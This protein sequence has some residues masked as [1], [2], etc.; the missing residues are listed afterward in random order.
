MGFSYT[1]RDKGWAGILKG[2]KAATGASVR[3]GILDDRAH[4][5]SKNGESIAE[6]VAVN[7]FGTGTIPSR[8]AWRNAFDGGKKEIVDSLERTALSVLSGD[9]R[10]TR[11]AMARVGLLVQKLIRESIDALTEPPN[12]PRWI[13][14][15]GNDKP[16][17][18]T[19]TTWNAITFEVIEGGRR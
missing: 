5:K 4:P 6:L 1:D 8:P 9:P 10:S 2:V 12:S 18:Y 7:E 17:E 15:K 3:V 19:R 13:R 16:L 14:I 11:V